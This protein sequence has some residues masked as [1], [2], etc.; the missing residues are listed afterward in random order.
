MGQTFCDPKFSGNWVYVI[1]TNW[2]S[3]LHDCIY[4]AVFIAKMSR[5]PIRPFNVLREFVHKECPVEHSDTGHMLCRRVAFCYLQ[6]IQENKISLQ[7][8][9]P[10]LS[11]PVISRT[12]IIREFG[13]NTNN[14]G[15]LNSGNL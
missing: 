10:E 12:P 6:F 5:R 8:R 2:L 4:F 1:S 13:K 9:P 14:Q 7:P 15:K 11:Y 3:I